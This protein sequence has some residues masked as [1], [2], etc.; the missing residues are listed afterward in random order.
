MA[1]PHD[2]SEYEVRPILI[3]QMGTVAIILLHDFRTNYWQPLCCGSLHVGIPP[4]RRASLLGAT[5][6]SAGVCHVTLHDVAPHVTSHVASDSTRRRA[7][8]QGPYDRFF[9]FSFGPLSPESFESDMQL[10]T[11]V[12]NDYKKDLHLTE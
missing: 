12:L 3:R 4:F 5:S 8:R 1:R 11:E 6:E 2:K 10:F 9:R 7:C